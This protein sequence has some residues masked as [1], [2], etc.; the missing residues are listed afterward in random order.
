MH[1]LLTLMILAVVVLGLALFVATRPAGRQFTPLANVGE[2]TWH[3]QKTYL[4]TAAIS[5]RYLL[6]KLGAD[7]QHADIAVAADIPIGFFTDEAAAAEDPVNVNLLGTCASTQL[8]VASAAIAL[9]AFVVADAGG[10]VRTLPGTTGT[11]YIVGRAL[12]AAAAN[13]DIIAID[14]C[15]PIQRVVP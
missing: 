6:A 4:A 12:T 1:S 7:A 9:G 15:A 10:K 11:Y 5:T 13:N 2:G 3:G 14:P 8:G